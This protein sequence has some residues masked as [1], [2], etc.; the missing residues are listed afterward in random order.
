MVVHD[1]AHAALTVLTTL[2]T[3]KVVIIT[4]TVRTRDDCIHPPIG[5]EHSDNE[6]EW[7][8]LKKL[9]IRDVKRLLFQ[10]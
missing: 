10:H 5:P 7:S 2:L 3:S 4:H 6:P 1:A 8:K 9:K